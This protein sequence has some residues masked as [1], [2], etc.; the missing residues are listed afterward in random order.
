MPSQHKYP[1]RAFRPPPDLYEEAKHAV[2][3]V[4]SDMNAHL[5]AFLR[6]LTRQTNELP[7]RPEQTNRS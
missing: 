6:W 5:V 3:E 2:A 4:D 7:Q 1:A